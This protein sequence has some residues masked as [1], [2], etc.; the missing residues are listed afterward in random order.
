MKVPSEE[1][2]REIKD[3]YKNKNMDYVTKAK[4]NKFI[5]RELAE[6]TELKPF[7]TKI[8][9]IASTY[10]KDHINA[11]INKEEFAGKSIAIDYLHYHNLGAY[12]PFAKGYKDIL[13]EAALYPEAKCYVFDIPRAINQQRLIELY[14]AIEILKNGWVRED[15]YETKKKN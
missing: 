12:I 11:I 10:D 7:Q 3:V 13:R 8:A 4:T 9:E 2:I 6:I 15:R 14:A 5:P 1:K